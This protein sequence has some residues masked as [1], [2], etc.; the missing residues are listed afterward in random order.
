MKTA[1]LILV[2]LVLLIG[3]GQVSADMII[4]TLGPG[5][6]YEGSGYGISGPYHSAYG[7][8]FTPTGNFVLSDIE[9]PLGIQS[10]T[11]SVVIQLQ[12][13]N[14]GLP[15]VSSR[16]ILF[17]TFRYLVTILRV[18]LQLPIPSLAPL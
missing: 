10:G 7:I 4:S 5:S 2:P 3:V 16:V 13:S 11:N 12:N 9:L 17:R 18:I 14:A 6:S 1:A 15:V 8:S